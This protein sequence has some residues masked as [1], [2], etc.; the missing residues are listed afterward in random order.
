MELSVKQALHT[1]SSTTD[2]STSIAVDGRAR[3][4]NHRRFKRMFSFGTG[5]WYVPL[6]YEP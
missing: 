4:L 6:E 1:L 2:V 3:Y 5:L